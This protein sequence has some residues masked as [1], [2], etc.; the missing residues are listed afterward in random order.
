MKMIGQGPKRSDAPSMEKAMMAEGTYKWGA[1][2]TVPQPL[3]GSTQEAGQLLLGGMLGAARRVAAPLPPGSGDML[4]AGM[5]APVAGVRVPARGEITIITTIAIDP[6]L[7]EPLVL[8]L[9]EVAL[10]LGV[11]WRSILA[12][13]R[14]LGFF[15]V[16]GRYLRIQVVHVV[17]CF[18]DAAEIISSFVGLRGTLSEMATTPRTK[19]YPAALPKVGPL[20]GALRR[21]TV[22]PW[23]E[24]LDGM[25]WRRTA[26]EAASTPP[27]RRTT[28]WATPGPIP[29]A[30]WRRLPA[31]P[32]IEGDCETTL[33]RASSQGGKELKEA[34]GKE[35]GSGPTQ[36][37]RQRMKSPRMKAIW[38]L[39]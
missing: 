8:M 16:V 9:V 11:S 10:R 4:L 28:S 35:G 32:P 18:L 37:A 27:A 21:C 24:L 1:T 31:H 5:V 39:S 20:A 14:I 29:R 13:G 38:T 22:G 3:G 6:S 19:S 36:K 26:T 12:T 30:R 25:A 33:A 34:G 2:R 15:F 17:H 7:L 23:C